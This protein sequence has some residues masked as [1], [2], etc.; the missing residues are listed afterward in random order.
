MTRFIFICNNRADIDEKIQSRCFP[1]YFPSIGNKIMNCLK[2]ILDK[3]N[4]MLSQQVIDNI[5]KYSNG[6]IRGLKVGQ[7]LAL[8]IKDET[9]TKKQYI[10][11]NNGYLVKIRAINFKSIV[12]DGTGPG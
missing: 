11:K 3:E 1:I 6:D 12:V 2:K 7:Q 8:F 5:V 4:I 10:S 9:N